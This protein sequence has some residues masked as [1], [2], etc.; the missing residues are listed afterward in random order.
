MSIIRF[1]SE[2]DIYIYPTSGGAYRMHYR[3]PGTATEVEVGFPGKSELRAAVEKLLGKGLRA[4]DDLLDRID[5]HE[6][7]DCWMSTRSAR[8][9]EGFFNDTE[10]DAG[11][12]V[13]VQEGGNVYGYQRRFIEK[14]REWP[15]VE[16]ADQLARLLSGVKPRRWREYSY[17]ANPPCHASSSGESPLLRRR[18]RRRSGG[19]LLGLRGRDRGA[20]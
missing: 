3:P 7:G 1:S 15:R 11:F 16:T 20:G 5:A 17:V 13:M 10:V 8:K 12:F 6:Y 18:S 19:L 14:A 4:P 9:I 2:C